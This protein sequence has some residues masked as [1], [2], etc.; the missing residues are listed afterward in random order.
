MQQRRINR[1]LLHTFRHDQGWHRHAT[2][3]KTIIYEGY[4]HRFHWQLLLASGTN[5]HLPS[6]ASTHLGL[7]C[8]AATPARNERDCSSNVRMT[9]SHISYLQKL[10]RTTN[11]RLYPC[12]DWYLLHD[13]AVLYGSERHGRAVSKTADSK[14]SAPVVRSPTS[15]TPAFIAGD[16]VFVLTL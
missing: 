9:S 13:G 3:S 6:P 10:D 2:I 11:D 16:V 7:L 1:V 4:D 12:S 14:S 15:P 8:L 5:G